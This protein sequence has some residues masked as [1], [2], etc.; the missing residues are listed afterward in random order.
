MGDFNEESHPRD[1]N[2][3]FSG[4]QMAFAAKHGVSGAKRALDRYK[5]VMS[6]KLP[7]TNKKFFPPNLDKRTWTE[8]QPPGTGKSDQ[9]WKDHFVGGPGLKTG[10][11]DDGIGKPTAERAREVHDPLIKAAFAGKKTAADLKE[12]KTAILTMGGPA[13]GK[14]CVLDQMAK[15]GFDT[16]EFVH[17]DPDMHKEGIPEYRAAIADKKNTYRWAGTLAH[18]ESS[19]IGKQIRDQA[20]EKGHHLVIDG[21]G[22]K[23]EKFVALIEHLK[24]KG[25]DVHVHFPSLSPEEGAKRSKDRAEISGRFVPERYALDMHKAV[26]KGLDKIMAAAPHFTMYNAE[27]NFEKV[28]DRHGPT[29]GELDKGIMQAFTQNRRDKAE[30]RLKQKL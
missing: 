30:M 26:D 20:I 1:A 8:L 22:G 18:E 13:S 29:G 7:D 16:S 4:G 3:R 24:S 12:Q 2:G 28:L 21:S 15:N 10:N 17:V 14:G 23:P 27:S 19:Y 25:Y 11:P 6:F 9:T 5:Q